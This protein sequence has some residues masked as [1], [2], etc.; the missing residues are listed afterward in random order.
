MGRKFDQLRTGVRNMRDEIRLLETAFDERH[1]PKPLQR[2][3]VLAELRRLESKLGR[4]LE[5]ESSKEHE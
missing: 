4:I 3:E 5:L 1:H 2:S